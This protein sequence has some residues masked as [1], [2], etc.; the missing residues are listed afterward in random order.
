VSRLWKGYEWAW[1]AWHRVEPLS[2]EAVLA[3]GLGVYRGPPRTLRDG[4]VVA[5][6]MVL[7][8]LHF[9]RTRVTELHRR[10]PQRTVGLAFRRE[11]ERALM[12]LA[13]LA[14]EHPHYRNVPAFHGT[15]LF[16][17]G[18]TRLG[19]EIHPLEGQW[20]RRL[21]GWYQRMLLRRD[22]PLGR[23][24]LHRRTLEPQTIWLSRGELLSR[25]RREK[26]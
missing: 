15:T 13:A 14:V 1:S 26:R 9:N 17:E 22:H 4:T 21:L 10:C 3:L 24:R 20:R 8:E 18:A 16:W 25:Y 11:L 5:P 7:G 19:F 12:T 6:G 23:R 2:C